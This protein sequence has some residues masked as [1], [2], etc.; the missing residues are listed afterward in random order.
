MHTQGHGDKVNRT[1]PCVVE[2][3]QGKNIVQVGGWYEDGSQCV[4]AMAEARHSEVV[5]WDACWSGSGGV[6]RGCVTGWP[7]DKR[8]RE[9]ITAA[10]CLDVLMTDIVV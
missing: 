6:K 9:T 10:S 3:L 7:S 1:S 2:A 4:M 5:G 8:T